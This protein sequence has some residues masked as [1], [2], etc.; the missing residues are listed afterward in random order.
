MVVAP[1]VREKLVQVEGVVNG[2]QITGQVVVLVTRHTSRIPGYESFGGLERKGKVWSVITR[3]GIES[4]L[5]V[6]CV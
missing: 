6:G 2:L 4:N 1:L 5:L 3:Q